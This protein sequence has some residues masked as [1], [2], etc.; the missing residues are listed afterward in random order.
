MVIKHY[1]LTTLRLMRSKWWLSII[2][3]F[4]LTSGII[5]FVLIWL[6][7]IDRSGYLLEGHGLNRFYSLDN[8]LIL[9]FIILF[10]SFVYFLVM[11]SQIA[12]RQKEL[13]WRKYYGET[14]KGIIRILMLETLIFILI[15]F[16]LS[17]VLIDQIA[18]VFN[19]IT[20]KN[21]DLRSLG[22]TSDL[23]LTLLFLSILGFAVGLLPSIWYAKNRAIDIL[24]KLP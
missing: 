6:Y 24:K 17:L 12:I 4:S 3:V 5:S 9:G 7:Y 14:N 21:I 23:V 2:K 10:T 16:V 19:M 22:S 20:S 18:P 15:A 11:K 13:F 8:I 1:I